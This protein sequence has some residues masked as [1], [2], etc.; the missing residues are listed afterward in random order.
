[1]ACPGASLVTRWLM[2]FGGWSACT[3]YAVFGGSSRPL[4]VR[5]FGFPLGD[6]RHSL[7]PQSWTVTLWL[8]SWCQRASAPFSGETYTPTSTSLAHPRGSSSS[9]EAL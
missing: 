7:T 3:S 8:L 1:M 5:T 4:L 6:V 2:R 9:S